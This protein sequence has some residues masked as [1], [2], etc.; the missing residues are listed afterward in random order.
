M[1]RRQ[2]LIASTG[3]AVAGGCASSRATSPQETALARLERQRGGRLGVMAVDLGS[4]R[5]LGHRS[6]E[7]FPLCSTFKTLLAAAILSRTDGN[8][9][10]LD[11]SIRY[12]AADLLEHA[13]ITR[14]NIGRGNMTVGELCEAAVTVSDNTAANL[15]L[16]DLGGLAAFN[17][18]CRRL[19]DQVTR[20][21]RTEPRLNEASPGDPRDTTTPRAMV[22]N[23]RRLFVGDALP[24][25]ARQRLVDWHLRAAVGQAR[26]RAGLPDGWSLAHKTG[27][28]GHGS[29]NDIGV[30]WPPGRAPLILAAY[31]TESVA[32]LPQLEAV[33]AEVGRIVAEL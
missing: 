14:T 8:Q 7:R 3:I 30:A 20:L 1:H 18:Y 28:G 32:P 26:L 23:L 16:G 13:P 27:T 33:L 5:M 15:L 31:Y 21:D 2:F 19:G 10:G 17:A 24:G 11:R 25:T 4:G 22:E 12:G 29:T 6:D 9:A